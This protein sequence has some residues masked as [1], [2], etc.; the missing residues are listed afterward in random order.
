[1]I[2]NSFNNVG[3][4]SLKIEQKTF[5]STSASLNPNTIFII[6]QPFSDKYNNYYGSCC[7][8]AS[9]IGSRSMYAERGNGHTSL[10]T[11]NRT[12]KTSL[13]IT[14]TSDGLNTSY[15]LYILE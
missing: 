14:L 10:C 6:S 11:L 12:S 2:L 5:S 1:M 3:G 15:V 7:I 8:D 9:V 13:D 4:G